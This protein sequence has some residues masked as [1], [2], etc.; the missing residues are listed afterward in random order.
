MQDK[1]IATIAVA[2]GL[3]LGGCAI[4]IWYISRPDGSTVSQTLRTA[5]NETMA[6]A[7]S[8]LPTKT[9]TASSNPTNT[10]AN[11]TQ[12]QQAAGNPQASGATLDPKQFSRYDKYVNDQAASFATISEGSGA[13]AAAG[14]KVSVNYRGWLTNGQIFDENI[15]PSKPFSFALGSGQVIRGWD[16]GVAGMRVG[17]ERLIIIPPAVGY[18]STGKGPIPGNAVL[19]FDVKVVAVE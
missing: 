19:V 14:K 4:L 18:G 5:N 9:G 2:V 13:E 1:V 10:T 17:G 8:T 11:N 15:D 7:G 3:A 12:N 16:Q 6:A